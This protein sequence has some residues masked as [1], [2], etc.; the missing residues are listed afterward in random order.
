MNSLGSLHCYF[1]FMFRLDSLYDGEVEI[2]FSKRKKF[3]TCIPDIYQKESIKKMGKH[4]AFNILMLM[5][6]TDPICRPACT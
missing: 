5:F 2:F 6:L 3:V 1:I 4:S